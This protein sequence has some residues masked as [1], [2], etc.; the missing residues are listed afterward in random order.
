MQL[1]SFLRT[2]FHD[3]DTS[4]HN[5]G[6]ARND[7]SSCKDARC[8][9]SRNHTDIARDA[10]RHAVHLDQYEAQTGRVAGLRGRGGS[11]RRGTREY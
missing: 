6:K 11:P 4:R 3:P 1:H 9:S 8:S 7:A 10:Q 5:V 2:R